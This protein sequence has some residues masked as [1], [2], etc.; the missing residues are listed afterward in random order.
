[1]TFAAQAQA[2][3]DRL[4]T[5]FGNAA[6]FK[7]IDTEPYDPETGA[8]TISTSDKSIT[9]AGPFGINPAMVDGNL[10]RFGDAR[11]LI[12]AKG[13]DWTPTTTEKIVVLSE[14]WT[15]IEVSPI[16]AQD[17]TI[18]WKCQVRK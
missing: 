8:A 5:K 15:I 4:V 18:A 11:I 14:T 12:S 9:V 2:T 13:V 16:T 6:T 7:D 17:T 3:V 1:M 10:V